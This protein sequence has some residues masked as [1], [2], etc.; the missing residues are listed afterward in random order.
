MTNHQGRRE[1]DPIPLNSEHNG[2]EMIAIAIKEEGTSKGKV[3]RVND[4]IIA[5][6]AKRI[7]LDAIVRA[8]Q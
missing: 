5:S 1:V 8:M 6:Y 2:G 4:I 3:R 7:I